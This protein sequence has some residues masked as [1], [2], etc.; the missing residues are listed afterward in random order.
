MSFG[1]LG[2]GEGP[3]DPQILAGLAEAERIV[4][5]G[6]YPPATGQGAEAPTP[7]S[8][9]VQ[10]VLVTGVVAMAAVARWFT[11]HRAQR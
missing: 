8:H 2:M 7:V 9:P 4:Q 3:E 1:Q 10:I 11:P 5:S 6:P